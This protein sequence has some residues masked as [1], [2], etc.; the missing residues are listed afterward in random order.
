MLANNSNNGKI[1]LDKLFPS[2]SRITIQ[3]LKIDDESVKYIT[4]PKDS[5]RI[6]DILC[7]R[8]KDKFEKT[9]GIFNATIVDCTSGVG[10][11]V[12]SFAKYFSNVVAIELDTIRSTYL[13]NNVDAYGVKNVTVI[14]GDS[15]DIFP[16]LSHADVVYM[17]PPWG[18]SSYKE[19]TTL[20]LLMSDRLI[21]D[22][23]L[24]MF[25]LT[26]TIALPKLV[27]LKLPVNYDLKHL[28][29]AL[30]PPDK[31][32]M[33]NVFRHEVKR[34]DNSVKF[35][36]VS[37]EPNNVYTSLTSGTSFA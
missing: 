14:N 24:D 23:I 1:I 6:Q 20:Q 29:N 34:N 5:K 25:D 7:E 33:F 35:Y 4:I 36:I 12:L 30:N 15:I 17:D 32:N 8:L 31:E 19:L 21:E 27:V 2:T 10:G 13:K 37:I 9:N 3:K 22:I 26:K 11:D 16:K 18:G 28:L